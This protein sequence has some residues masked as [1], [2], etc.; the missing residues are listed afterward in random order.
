MVVGVIVIS[1][2]KKCNNLNSNKSRNLFRNLNGNFFQTN[3]CWFYSDFIKEKR[4]S[5]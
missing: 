4:F 5:S 3:F 1:G 2:W